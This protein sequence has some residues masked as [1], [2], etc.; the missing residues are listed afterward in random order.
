MA[1]TPYT[2]KETQW[3][4]VPAVLYQWAA[5]PDAQSG[6]PVRLPAH[7]GVCVSISGGT[8]GTD[9]VTWQGTLDASTTPAATAYG[10]LHFPDGNNC[11]QTA[12]GQI[13]EVLEHALQYR[14]TTSGGDVTCAVNVRLLAL[15]QWRP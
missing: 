15:N 4:G 11:A 1:T 9:T 12:L 5:I 13:D 10:T 7:S 14:P 2:K 6:D 8:I 3:N